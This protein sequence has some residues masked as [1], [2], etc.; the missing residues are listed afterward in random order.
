MACGFAADGGGYCSIGRL[1]TV[2]LGG[3]GEDQA[4]CAEADDAR[5]AVMSTVKRSGLIAMWFGSYTPGIPM[6]ES[7]PSWFRRFKL[8]LT[9]TP[10]DMPVKPQR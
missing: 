9:G 8:A 7:P 4:P 3:G 1:G 5:L 2:L 10:W 6:D